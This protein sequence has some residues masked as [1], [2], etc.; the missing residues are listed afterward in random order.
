MIQQH[1]LS[2]PVYDHLKKMI[3]KGQLVPGQKLVQEDLARQL[4]VSRTPLLKALQ[5]L[6]HEMLVQSI[7]RRGMYVKDVTLEEMIDVY[8]CREGIECTAIRLVI[9]RSSDAEIKKF[10]PIFQPF[11]ESESIDGKKYGMADEQFHDLIISLSKNSILQR[12]STLSNIHKRVYVYGL[13]RP[14]KETLREHLDM[15][16]AIESR[17]VKKA[18]QAVKAHIELSKN[19]LISKLST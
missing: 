12:M 1:D 7:P 3:E 17:D 8:D 9:E 15:I 16:E 10:R 4:G 18:I 6:E 14:P 19:I 13:I 2:K 5:S 11:Y